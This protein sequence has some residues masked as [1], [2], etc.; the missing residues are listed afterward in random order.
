MRRKNQIFAAFFAK[1]IYLPIY[2][3]PLPKLAVIFKVKKDE[4]NINNH[5]SFIISL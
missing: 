5:S 2:Y 3:L 1:F 4:A